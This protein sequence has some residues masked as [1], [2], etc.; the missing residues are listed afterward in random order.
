MSVVSSLLKIDA[1]KLDL[2]QKKYNIKRLSEAAGEPVVFVLSGIDEDKIDEIGEMST[3]VNGDNVKVDMNEVHLGT[4]VAGVLDPDLRDKQLMEHYEVK[5]PH[6][7][8]K[9]LLLKGERVEIYNK[10][11]NLSGYDDNAVEEVKKQ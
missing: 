3:T 4:I 8:V 2:P 10:I 1:G 9:K 7:L 6:D 5:T 11:S